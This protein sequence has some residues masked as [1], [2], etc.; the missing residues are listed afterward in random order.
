MQART[1][2]RVKNACSIGLRPGGT[3][4]IDAMPQDGAADRIDVRRLRAVLEFAVG[5]AA[6]AGRRHADLP[7]PADLITIARTVP[8][9][10]RLEPVLQRR[11]RR[12]LDGDE[13]LRQRLADLATSGQIDEI[14]MLWLRRPDGW[15]EE[16]VALV[17]AADLRDLDEE[18]QRRLRKEEHRRTAAEESAGRAR[19]EAAAAERRLREIEASLEQRSAVADE[20]RRELAGVRDELQQALT[21]ARHAGD[22][23][24][25]ANRRLEKALAAR[26]AADEA[27]VRA[28]A[29]RDDVLADRA[30]ASTGSA[31][32][33]HLLGLAERLTAGL[34]SLLPQRGTSRDAPTRR[35]PIALPGGIVGNSELAV[36]HLLGTGAAVIVD[37]YN[38]AKNVW[39]ELTLERQRNALIA[40]LE[41]LTRSSGCP[42]TVVF[43]GADVVGAVADTRRV[44]RVVYS[45]TGVTADDVIRDIVRN[46]PPTDPVVVVTDDQEI[47]RD[48]R[49][50]GANVV[51]VDGLRRVWR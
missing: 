49:A 18:A 37:G 5:A 34:S 7:V 42:I 50:V 47:V 46:M 38:V 6:E 30:R 17:G 31:E 9:G 36:R 11:V 39:P 26:A 1:G 25:A 33:S 44:V 29:V 13:A 15:R 21:A 4:T 23:E 8:G 22:R 40:E 10:Q 12:L 45:P 27:A 51:A 28:E 24:Q 20:L 3:G 2:V 32:L 14:G 43:D 19:D 35:V 41:N 48:V 16:I